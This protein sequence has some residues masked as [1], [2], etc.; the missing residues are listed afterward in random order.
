MLNWAS[1]F[2]SRI[3]E[4]QFVSRCQMLKY[5]KKQFIFFGIRFFSILLFLFSSSAF[6][7]TFSKNE[8]AFYSSLFR[9]KTKCCILSHGFVPIRSFFSECGYNHEKKY[10]ECYE[11]P[12]KRSGV[13]YTA[14]QVGHGLLCMATAGLWEIA[15]YPIERSLSP[16]IIIRA[17]YPNRT[18]NRIEKIEI[19]RD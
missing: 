18:S 8:H 3:F 14:R 11:Q 10:I 9:C 2:T 6:P 5:K 15:Y 13:A 16:V 17:T 19:H 12:G 7:N 1:D 4:P